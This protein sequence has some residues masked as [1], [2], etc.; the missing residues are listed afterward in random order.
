MKQA[1][2]IILPVILALT[3]SLQIE[4]MPPEKRQHLTD[5]LNAILPRLDN[6]NDSLDVLYDL[7]DVA[8]YQTRSDATLRAYEV[9]LRTD[10]IAARGDLLRRISN[11]NLSNDSMQALALEEAGRLPEGN[12]R[13]E[14]ELFI[15][16]QRITGRARYTTGAERQRNLINLITNYKNMLHEERGLSAEKRFY[17][18][19]EKLYALCI[20]MSLS[21]RSH[22]LMDYVDSLGREIEKLPKDMLSIRNLYY[23]NTAIAYTNNEVYDKAI[24]A[25]K[26]LLAVM[27]QLETSN[28]SKGREFSDYDLS[29]YNSYR[30]ILSNYPVLTDREVE[31]YYD[32]IKEIARAHPDAESDFNNSRRPTIYYLMAK[33]RYAEALPILKTAIEDKRHEAFRRRFTAF[34]VEAAKAT[35]DQQAL[36]D[37]SIEYNKLLEDFISLRADENLSELQVVYHVSS[38]LD[39]NEDLRT[40]SRDSEIA[41]QKRFSAILMCCGALLVVLLVVAIV[42][43]MRSKKLAV[44]LGMSNVSLKNERDNLRHTQAELI[45]ARDRARQADRHKTDFINNMSHEVSVPLNTIVEYSQ[46]IVENVDVNKRAYL[47]R[48][49]QAIDVSADLLRTLI[50][51]VLD[52]SS[53]DNTQ[54]SVVKQP[55]GINLLCET[56]MTTRRL[57][58]K[59]GVDMVFD[60]AGSQETVIITDRRRVEQVLINLLS[61]ASKFTD[62]GIIHLG[63]RFHHPEHLVTFYVSDTGIGIPEE[64]RE[65]IFE[66]FVK[67]NRFSQGNGLG[68]AICR[69]IAKLLDGRIWVDGTY[70]GPGTRV[71]FEIPID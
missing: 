28:H 20:Y 51:D 66:R 43:Y 49:A 36:L 67:L 29:R 65:V 7:V 27:D 48:F 71:C 15:K 69:M 9:S 57:Y 22:L 41:R 19:L 5:S 10:N 11:Y 25:D 62:S 42:F 40:N 4:A 44:N 13:F 33:K 3:A 18:R 46:L 70:P 54:L 64:K 56:A 23:T 21:T 55:V 26:L 45:K 61:N 39:E 63:Y 6:A 16:T 35:G 47:E 37:A 8:D 2:K 50:N 68:L 30:R 1:L 14:T 59:E 34:I 38:L 12:I 58:A 32:K 53:L 52:I 31:Y 60:N 24:A 17:A